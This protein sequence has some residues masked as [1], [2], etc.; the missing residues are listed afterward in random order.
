LF[1]FDAI[2]GAYAPFLPYLLT[3]IVLSVSFSFYSLIRFK[4]GEQ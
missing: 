4:D 1:Y 2:P 3:L